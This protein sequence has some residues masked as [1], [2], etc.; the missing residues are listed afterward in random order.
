[1]DPNRPGWTHHKARAQSNVMLW[2]ILG[3]LGLGVIGFLFQA[4][5]KPESRGKSGQAARVAPDGMVLG[6][7]TQLPVDSCYVLSDRTPLLSECGQKV[8]DVETAEQRSLPPGTQI[9]VIRT[10]D[11]D[12]EMWYY[13]EA[14]TQDGTTLGKGWI[15]TASL[16]NQRL[17]MLR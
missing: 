15:S 6:G 9:G 4:G 11:L 5:A 13:V 10:K 12:G 8:S 17:K 3:A 2:V 7:T 16:K 14:A 1:M